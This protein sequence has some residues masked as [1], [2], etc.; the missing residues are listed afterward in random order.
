MIVIPSEFGLV[1]FVGTRNL[2]A[3]VKEVGTVKYTCTSSVIHDN[4]TDLL[5]ADESL[6]ILCP[7]I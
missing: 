7:P 6:P 3:V 1:I 5:D 4:L 2:L